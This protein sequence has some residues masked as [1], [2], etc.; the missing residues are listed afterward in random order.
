MSEYQ[1]YEFRAVDRPLTEGEMAELRSLSSRATIT[2]T[3]FQN[4]YNWGDFRGDPLVL[5]Q[6]YFDAFV[7]VANWGTRQFMLRLP[8]TLLPPETANR[9]AIE[10]AVQ[11]RTSGDNVILEFAVEEGEPEWAEGEGWLDSLLPLRD[12]IARGDLRALYIGW[13]SA[14][15]MGDVEDEEEEA[16]LREPPVPPGLKQLSVPLRKLADFLQVDSDLVAVAAE[17]SEAAEERPESIHERQEWLQRLPDSYKNMLLF[18]VMQ[19][20]GMEARARL[21]QRFRQDSAR[22][23]APAERDGRTMGQLL[24]AAEEH[25]KRRTQREREQAARERERRA[26]EEAAARDKYL[27]GLAGRKEAT[28]SQ[29]ES[30]LQARRGPEYEQAARHVVDLREVAQRD[31]TMPDFAARLSELRARHA[32]KPAFIRRLDAAAL[33]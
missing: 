21:L 16:D 19:G 13:L 27:Q 25:G 14:I 4:E 7:Y 9:Y 18:Q 33:R 11:V 6:K 5:M 2:A 28:W 23:Q 29:I 1:Y 20:E 26:R 32:S 8:A 30:L 31:G 22:P 3:S 24:V 17:R 15:W 12:D 10:P